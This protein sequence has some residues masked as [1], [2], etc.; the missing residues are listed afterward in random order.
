M[1]L[2]GLS[3]ARGGRAGFFGG[4]EGFAPFP[5]TPIAGPATLVVFWLVSSDRLGRPKSSIQPCSGRQ[6]DAGRT[7][8]MSSQVTGLKSLM[9]GCVGPTANPV[10]GRTGESVS[11]V[12]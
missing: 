4:G 11:S 8:S 7:A 5:A 6:V 1:G 9:R 10:R 12:G 3:S 2:D